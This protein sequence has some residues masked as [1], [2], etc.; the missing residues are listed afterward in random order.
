MSTPVITTSTD[1]RQNEALI[2]LRGLGGAIVGGVLGYFLFRWLLTQGMYG[3]MIPGVGLG[4]AA[5]LAAR[6]KSQTLGILC[7]VA[8]LVLLVVSEWSVFPFAKDDSLSFF[9]THLHHKQ[10]IT[11]IMIG[12]GAAFAYWFGTG[13]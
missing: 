9:L 1:R 6:G 3:I 11:L 7:G 5:G 4:L 8:A 12:L 10:P 2:I 13:R